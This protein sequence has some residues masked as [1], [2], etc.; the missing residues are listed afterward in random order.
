[1]ENSVDQHT[2]MNRVRPR[3]SEKKRALPDALMMASTSSALREGREQNPP[4]HNATRLGAAASCIANSNINAIEHACC[5]RSQHVSASNNYAVE[6]AR[7]A[8]FV[9]ESGKKT[10]TVISPSVRISSTTYSC[11]FGGDCLTHHPTWSQPGSCASSSTI[12]RRGMQ[13]KQRRRPFPMG[14]DAT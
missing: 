10:Q 12:Q 9:S 8:T 1:M 13:N 11:M 7:V 6:Q 4:Q 3:D 14:K 5:E 2:E